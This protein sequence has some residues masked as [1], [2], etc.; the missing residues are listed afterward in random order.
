MLP[1]SF[2]MPAALILL[3]GGLCSCFAGYRIFRWVLAFF[4]FVFG[5][6][7]V[8]AAMGSDQTLWMIAAWLVGGLIGAVILFAAYFVG[9]AL[10]GAGIGAGLAM[11]LWA[12]VNR[13][14]GIWPV[15]ILAV[16]GAIGAL[17]VQRHVI[18]VATAFA[19]A[20]TA[21]VGAAELVSGR[22]LAAAGRQMVHV[23][24]LDPLPNTRWDLIAFIV[25]GLV[26]LVIQLRT[27][28]GKKSK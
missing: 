8:G 12:A 2:Q 19:G 4:G 10:I 16:L 20:Q 25:L 28:T 5:A 18:I 23:Y 3:V 6:L 13:E 15:I 11:V 14:P 17:A 1:G 7:F 26:G 27:S 24:P 21:V 9:V 22:N